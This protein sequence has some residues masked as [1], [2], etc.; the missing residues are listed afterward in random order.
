MPHTGK[1]DMLFVSEYP[2]HDEIQRGVPFVSD[3]GEILRIE[4][5]RLGVDMWSQNLTNLW[6]HAQNK[7][8]DCFEQ[9][10]IS[11]TREMAGRK[12]LLMGAELCRF[13]LG[14]SVT[15]LSGLEVRS[16]LFPK[17]VQF[18]MVAP[19]PDSCLHQN[20]GELR[21]ALTKFIRRCK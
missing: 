11:L 9:G 19:K 18:V 16:D 15:D 4:L 5:A 8:P 13:F 21:L 14:E 20:A 10:V 17:S 7:N 2:D 3:G 1:T 6:M 12:V